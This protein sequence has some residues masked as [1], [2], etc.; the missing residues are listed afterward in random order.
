MNLHLL[1]FMCLLHS[2]LTVDYCID[3]RASLNIRKQS[4]LP[5]SE[6]LPHIYLTFIDELG[7]PDFINSLIIRH[8]PNLYLSPPHLFI[9]LYLSPSHLN[10]LT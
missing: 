5:I 9:Y 7:S 1:S 4:L 6:N 10:F 8:C 2:N 3:F